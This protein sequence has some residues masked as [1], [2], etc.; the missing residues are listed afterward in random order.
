MRRLL[1][2]I[3][4]V[5]GALVLLFGSL[6]AF[7]AATSA[8]PRD[9]ESWERLAN[10]PRPRGEVA[11]AVTTREL[12]CGPGERCP[13][14]ERLYVVGG[15][16]GLGRTTDLVHVYDERTRGWSGAP[17]IPRPRHHPAAVATEGTVYVTGGSESATSWKPERD[18]WVLTPAS[19]RWRAL[20][21]MPEGRMGH[22]MVALGRKLYV[23]GG[24]GG[25][26]VL[27]YDTASGKWSRGASMPVPRDHLA[28][29]AAGRRIFAIGGRDE[30]VLARVD[31]YDPRR[32]RWLR[33][34]VLPEPM[35]AMGAGLLADGIHVVGGEDPATLGGGV[36][37]RHF[38]L[39]LEAGT[40]TPAPLPVVPVHGAAAGVMEGRLVLAGGARRQG[41]LSVLG[42]TGITQAYSAAAPRA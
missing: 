26:A 29:V 12:D 16:A 36:I 15:L 39:D 28:A 11:T 42:W 40:W 31:I 38:R 9:A 35:S 41:S 21:M 5:V 33:G 8:D 18:L 30:S 10:L 13:R 17:K 19:R 25:S 14:V 27:I 4:V 37:D 3:A 2:T 1:R 7:L 24:R 22:Q 32:N 6:V 23:V 34:P 20:A